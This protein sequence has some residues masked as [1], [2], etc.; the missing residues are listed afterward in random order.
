MH[1]KR[2]RDYYAANTGW[3]W[4][5]QHVYSGGESDTT[6][7][8]QK[9]LNQFGDSRAVGLVTDRYRFR[10][11][12]MPGLNLPSARYLVYTAR[13]PV[14]RNGTDTTLGSPAMTITAHTSLN[15]VSSTRINAFGWGTTIANQ[16]AQSHG[17]HNFAFHT[18][19]AN[20]ATAINAV[21]EA[22]VARI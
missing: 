20:V 21:N 16:T 2:G 17:G 14:N 3:L 18:A 5:K 13:T 6:Y 11:V 8:D 7:A 12:A 15:L 4:K 22:I 19:A 9:E 10:W 1:H